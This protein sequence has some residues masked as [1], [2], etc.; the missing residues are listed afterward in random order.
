MEFIKGIMGFLLGACIFLFFLAAFVFYIRAG[1]YGAHLWF[2]W[3]GWWVGALAVL[4]TVAL[5]N[6]GLMA[7][8]IVGAYG[9]YYGWRWDWW[10]VAIVFFPGFA[11]MFVS[12]IF[13]AI[14]GVLG[15]FFRSRTA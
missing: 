4:L 1:V 15:S 5:R 8:M 9:A 12:G 10:L 2:G 11:L 14:G 7:V 6:L 3:S 13:V